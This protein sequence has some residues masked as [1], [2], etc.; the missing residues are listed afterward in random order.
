M[1]GLHFVKGNSD[2]WRLMYDTNV[3]GLNICSKEAIK[4]MKENDIKSGHIIN[5]NRY[6]H[7]K[8]VNIMHT[9]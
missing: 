2:D 5:I 8:N 6:L 3:M 7:T 4:I 9:N 1:I